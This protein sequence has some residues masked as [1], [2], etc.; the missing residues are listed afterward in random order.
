MIFV[1]FSTLFFTLNVAASGIISDSSKNRLFLNIIYFRVK[2]PQI[3]LQK[4]NHNALK[5][6]L[7]YISSFW[8]F[9]CCQPVTNL[10]W[11]RD[12]SFI[13]GSRHQARTINFKMILVLIPEVMSTYIKWI[14]RKVNVSICT[15]IYKQFSH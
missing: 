13:R 7:P 5:L 12:K 14:N 6:K 15:N 2:R 8:Q 11:Y 4:I 1:Y 3:I 9:K 10:S